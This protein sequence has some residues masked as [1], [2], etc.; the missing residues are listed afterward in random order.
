MDLQRLHD[1]I[2]SWEIPKE[3]EFYFGVLKQNFF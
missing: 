3:I 1:E 2:N